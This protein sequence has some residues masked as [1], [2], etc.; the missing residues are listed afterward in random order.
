MSAPS[1]SLHDSC[2]DSVPFVLPTFNG[3]K[4]T[5]Q[6]LDSWKGTGSVGSELIIVNDLSTDG[7][8][9]FL[10]GLDLPGVRVVHNA[11]NLGYAASC[12]HGASLVSGE[13]LCFLN[14]DLVLHGDWLQPML[15]GLDS[16]PDAGVVGCVQRNPRTGLVD[17][18]GMYF[19]LDGLPRHAAHKFMNVSNDTYTEWSA[20]TA[21]CFVIRKSIFDRVGGFD[22]SYRNGYEDVD[23]C[24]RL[25]QQ[26]YR[27]YVANRSRIYHHVSQ[28]PGRKL[29]ED[30]N[31][32]TFMERWGT[33]TRQLGRREWP[34]EYLRICRSRPGKIRLGKLLKALWMRLANGS[35][36]G[37]RT[38][39]S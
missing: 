13:V 29:H 3:L 18:A 17:H 38:P 37:I 14:N 32:R 1:V 30:R 36:A 7:T 9:E 24:M 10:D 39:T 5:R 4:L 33:L 23:L 8:R 6:F 2:V 16:L 34:R 35:P 12:N 26:G 27:H 25:R 20:V 19:D 22:T 11:K 28:S 15:A 31:A 21:A